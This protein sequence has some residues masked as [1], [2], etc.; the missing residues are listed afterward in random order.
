M[1]MQFNPKMSFLVQL[2]VFLPTSLQTNKQASVS[3]WK[4]VNSNVLTI[5]FA[6]PPPPRRR[7]FSTPP[8]LSC[9]LRVRV[10][11]SKTKF[12]TLVNVTKAIKHLPQDFRFNTKISAFAEAADLGWQFESN[13]RYS[14]CNACPQCVCEWE[15][16]RDRL[17][18]KS[19][20][21]R[22]RQRERVT[23]CTNLISFFFCLCLAVTK[24]LFSSPKN[25]GTKTQWESEWDIERKKEEV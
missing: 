19:V 22:E 9:L 1:L 23:K 12:A 5:K 14:M 25:D 6:L 3:K 24:I 15:R 18:T 2:P 7:S 11:P 16:K 13:V 21:E 20:Q 8:L 17:C 10:Q 4:H